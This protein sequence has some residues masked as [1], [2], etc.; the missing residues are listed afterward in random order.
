MEY[1]DVI[2]NRRAVNYFDKSKPIEESLLR[3]IINTAVLAPS[4]F[5]LQPWRVIAVKTE[6]AKQDLYDL[7]NRQP[8]VLDAPVSLIIIGDR[9]G[10]R[11]ESRT[12]EELL[13]ITN[14][15]TVKG[16]KDAANYLY[17]SSEER[18]IKFAESNAGLLAM[19]IMYTAKSKGVDTHPMSGID[20][21]GI[22][23]KFKLKED[24]HP[25]MVI[26]MGYHDKS[27]DLYP[28]GFRYTYNEIVEE[29]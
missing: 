22:K 28:R 4:A 17:G 21:E 27:K 1:I 20:F 11:D 24:E 12:W 15:E 19:S 25:V 2:N 14:E 9:K 13:S 26:T 23:E 3:E 16:A 18:M 5:N 29:F 7:S 8:K 6:Q 10:F